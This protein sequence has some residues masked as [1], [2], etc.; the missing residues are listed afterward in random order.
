MQGGLHAFR[1]VWMG[2]IARRA[3]H[4]A[5]RLPGG[6]VGLPTLCA[7]RRTIKGLTRPA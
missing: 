6:S 7:I 3:R 4:V 2:Q 1:G 5:F